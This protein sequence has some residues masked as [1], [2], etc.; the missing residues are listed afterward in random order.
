MGR[1]EDV[2]S[3]IDE[4]NGFD[5]Q[6][7]ARRLL[8]REL[9]PNLNP[10]PD[11]DDLGQDARTEELPIEN[12]PSITEDNVTFAI[13]KTN[14]KSKLKR[15]CKRC[16][17]MGHDIDTFVF[18]TSGE[19]Q[20]TLQKE[21]K[22][23]IRD[24][25][26][27]E[28]IIYERTWFADVV[29]QP[30]HEKLIEEVLGI[31]PLNGDYYESI[32]GA[33]EQ[34]T[35]NT[36]SGITG[37][38]PQIDRK[39]PRSEMS[40]IHTELTEGN[41]VIVTGEGGVGKTGVLAQIVDQWTDG[42]E[43]FI[44]AR[45]FSECSTDTELRQA[46]DF[47]GS[48]S[49]AVGRVGRHESCLVVVDQ[50]DNIGGTPAAEVF[51]DFLRAVDGEDGVH[52][53]AGCRSWDLENQRVY[54]DLANEETFTTVTVSQLSSSEVRDVLADLEVTDY[55]DE[56]LTI[57]RNLLNL[58]IIAELQAETT[59]SQINFTA[60]KSQVE[61]WDRYQE[62]L[63]ER[64]TQGGQWDEQSGDEV[65]ARAIELAQT[66]LQD[67]SRV[68]PISLRRERPDKRLISRRVIINEFG[69]RYRFRHEELQ[70][71]FYA[72]NAVNRLGWTTP[73][74]V[75]EEIDERVAAGVFRWMLRILVKRGPS[76]PM[77]FLDAA[78][79]VDGLNY[80]AVS[81]ILDEI[82]T[83]DPAEVDD[84]VID[85]ALSQINENEQFC[86]YF[87]TNLESAAWMSIL[88]NRG[89]F[90]D[91]CGPVMTYLEQV[92]PEVPDL[93]VEI[94]QNTDTDHENFQA[95]FVKIAGQLPAEHATQC[96]EVFT[97]WLSEAE[98]GAGP[99]T[100][101]YTDLIKGLVEKDALGSAFSL[102]SALV[103][104]QPP[105][106]EVTERELENGET[107]VHKWQ[108]EARAPAR[109]YTIETAIE[110]VATDLLDEYD[111][112]FIDILEEK[113]RQAIKLEAEVWDA[114]P[115]ELRWP[116]YAGGSDLNN[117]K[118]KEVLLDGLR[119]FLEDWIAAAPSDSDRHDLITRYL[120]EIHLFRRLGLYLLSQNADAYPEL[121]REELLA[122][123]IYDAYEVRQEFFQLLQDGFPVLSET[124]QD[125][126]LEIIDDGP[127]RDE[128][129]EV[130]EEQADRFPD[131][132][133]GDVVDEEID[134]W[135]LRRLWMLRG[136]LSGSYAD[137]IEQLVETYGE[138][139][140]L[141]RGGSA[142]MGAVS[143]EGPMDQEEL[144]DLPAEEVLELCVE[145]DPK[146]NEDDT[147]FLTEISPR[148]LAQE[149]KTLVEESPEQFTP[150]LAILTE[151]ESV[152]ISEV[153]D[154][155]QNALDADRSFEWST[156]LELCKEAAQR[157]NGQVS[158]SR[159]RVCRLLDKGL[160]KEDSGLL[161]HQDTVR[162]LLLTLSEDLE[163]R[164]ENEDQRYIPHDNPLRTAI[165]AVRPVAVDTLIIYALERA[166]VEG[167]D[168]SD[169]EQESGLETEV[170]RCLVEKMEDPSTAVH[171]VFGKRLRNLYWLDRELVEENI[172]TIFPIDEDDESRD[173]F[174]AAWA[175]YLSVSPWIGDLYEEL[176][177]RYLHAVDLHASE[178]RFTGH[179]EGNRFVAH[180]LHTYLH[181]D[182]Q[183]TADDS[184]LPYF[185]ENTTPDTAGSAAWQLWRWADEDPEFHENWD[186]I[187]T[188]WEWRLDM[189]SDDYEDHAKEFGWF[190]EWLDLIS[191]EIAPPTVESILQ[192]TAPFL[193]YNRRGWKTLETYL[194][195]WVDTYP[196]CCIEIYAGLLQQPKLPDYLQFDEEAMSILET[197]LQAGDNT[198]ELALEV[199]EAVAE[200]D[201]TFLDLLRE[202]SVD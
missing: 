171:C 88:H 45:R 105:E 136:Y 181:S 79:S 141:E 24:E 17:E 50:L 154:G 65:R 5:F 124:E 158:S 51:T 34:E 188:L 31:P 159:K 57:G 184:L 180:T 27:W 167:F 100:V 14:T 46:F 72:W 185:Y 81:R 21:W 196:H 8:K 134:L 132:D 22:R 156:V 107:L 32:V 151:A 120:D 152:Y 122:E 143:F 62:T 10:L 199:T 178:G 112:E 60:I 19:V 38:I 193:V 20:N 175:A 9:F 59:H 70:D 44:D 80:Y 116:L 82:S 183:L 67:G 99:Y 200:H 126:V 144:R 4:M 3:A 55:S 198:R 13:S 194:A 69:E 92:G 168:G 130:A 64:E 140:H 150:H 77:E 173:R 115:E 128:L 83:W 121:V 41:A 118:L 39:L 49:D 119:S 148:G 26:G 108:T 161:D 47:N 98:I 109:I 176:K 12:L 35:D 104:P 37:T 68:F 18:V 160:S 186:A 91:P 7:L 16:R 76:P 195:Q 201:Q 174:G 63:A 89:Q 139:N 117:T 147:D 125:R 23:D 182:E 74:E 102:L 42:P 145:W 179:T 6:K 157:D 106:P 28:L 75:L 191:A 114:E 52:L 177:E 90:D 129:L 153:F 164:L 131:R 61:L 30:D 146:E 133:I 103:E 11:Q 86:E 94:I 56:L 192:D 58:S 25:Y 110:T 93:T 43:L 113:L 138:P 187:Q 190:V 202:Y 54:A 172:D 73:Q 197:A 87:Y 123:E 33:F 165:N 48:L 84:D 189:V 149:V 85:V 95:I 71:Y 40:E 137:R 15:D 97:E 1:E 2:L 36:L 96:V 53:V 111:I 101:Q 66:G 155:L 166:K 163:P 170:R 127:E 162:E 142:R 135:Q 78:L 29:T 169:E